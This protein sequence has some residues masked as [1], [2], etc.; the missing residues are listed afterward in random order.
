[1][2]KG[3]WVALV[4]VSDP[5]GYKAYITEN[6]KPLRKFGGC[7]LAR[8]GKS[9]TPEGQTRSRV[10]VVVPN[11]AAALECC[12]SPEYAKAMALREGKSIMDLTIVEGYDGPQPLDGKD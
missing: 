12:R 2:A 9:E 5:D 1:M 6:A 10:V 4:D 11:Y 8:G 3:Y 7:F